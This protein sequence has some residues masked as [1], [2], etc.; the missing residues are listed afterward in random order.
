MT[1]TDLL[2]FFLRFCL[3]PVLLGSRYSEP[4]VEQL[5]SRNPTIDELE[6][7]RYSP[8]NDPVGVGMLLEGRY[9]DDRELLK[10][11]KQKLLEPGWAGDLDKAVTAQPVIQGL[12]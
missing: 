11:Y 9:S 12:T 2:N 1:R 4:L 7:G 6:G 8:G 3:A 5:N 10:Y